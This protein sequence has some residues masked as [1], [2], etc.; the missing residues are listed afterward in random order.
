MYSQQT[1]QAPEPE[2]PTNAQLLHEGRDRISEAL[3]SLRVLLIQMDGDTWVE[4][5]RSIEDLE[6]ARNRVQKLERVI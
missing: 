2:E 5:D 3:D 1:Y 4:L 6:R